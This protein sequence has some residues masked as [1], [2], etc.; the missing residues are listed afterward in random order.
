MKNI[1]IIDGADNCTYSIYSVSE[2][3]FQIIFPGHG[4]DIEFA[5]DLDERIRNTPNESLYERLFEK[6]I[7]KKQVVGIH[8]TLFYEM[9]YKKDFYPIKRESE[10]VVQL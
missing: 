8:G 5:S 2:D 6:T 3:D 10:M 4:Q 1:Q 7:E 9:D